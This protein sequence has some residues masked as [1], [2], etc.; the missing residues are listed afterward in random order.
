MRLERTQDY[1]LVKQ[2]MSHQ[3]V[4]PWLCDDGSPAAEDFSPIE[5]D[6]ITYV[7]VSDPEPVGVFMLVP[8]STATVQIHTC[9]TPPCWGR[10]ALEATGLVIPWVFEH[11]PHQRLT[12]M[13]PSD[14]LLAMR[15]ARASGMTEYGVNPK[16]YLRGGSLLDTH[17]YGISKE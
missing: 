17:L 1:A 2:L 16:S 10:K 11:T 3:R 6:A 9:L 12:T 5:S 14:N 7:L 4:F 8:E 15:L 13:V